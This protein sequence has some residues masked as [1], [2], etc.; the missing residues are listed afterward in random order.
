MS[1]ISYFI[2]A[3]FIINNYIILFLYFFIVLF[4]TLMKGKMQTTDYVKV[5]LEKNMFLKCFKTE[6]DSL[7]ALQGAVMQE[8]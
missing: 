3:A 6:S 1:D 5:I 4:S 8:Q 2:G 7:V